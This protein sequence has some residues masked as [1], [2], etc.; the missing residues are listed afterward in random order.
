MINYSVVKPQIYSVVKLSYKVLTIFRI[1]FTNVYYQLSNK[2]N[3]LIKKLLPY[4]NN[5]CLK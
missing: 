2:R 5:Y 3:K 1:F 4:H